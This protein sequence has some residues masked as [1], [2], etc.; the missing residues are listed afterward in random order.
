MKIITINNVARTST[1]PGQMF[2]E[3]DNLPLGD[4]ALIEIIFL[5]W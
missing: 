4:L 3:S 2:V 5:F 1:K